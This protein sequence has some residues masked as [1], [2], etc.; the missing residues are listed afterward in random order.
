MKQNKT[1]IFLCISSVLMI[2]GIGTFLYPAISNYREN[3]LHEN[4]IQGYEESVITADQKK[5][6]EEWK[7]AEDYNQ[8]KSNDYDS[9]L[10]LE[11][12]GVMGYIEIPKIEVRLPI[13]HGSGEESL[14]KGVGH[15]EKTAVP[16][17]GKG[18]H[19]VLTG[20][21]G[22]PSAELFTRLDEL[23]EKDLFFIHVLDE[24][25]AY[26]VDQILT[27]LP[28]EVEKITGSPDQDYITLVTCTPYGVN[29]H[30]LLVRGIR[31]TYDVDNKQ[32][33]KENNFFSQNKMLILCGISIGIVIIIV[34][35]K[36]YLWKERKRKRRRRKKN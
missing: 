16:V 7:K 12:N 36:V 25:L 34:G 14:K 17:G 20:H 18:T 9:V 19:C 27:V 24:V 21:R 11:G 28:E 15:I 33:K 31:T 35:Y 1:G 22:L 3:R 13:Y 6:E 32:E 2:L 30:R 8:N 23:E 29:S 10:N 26:E 4:I 5:K